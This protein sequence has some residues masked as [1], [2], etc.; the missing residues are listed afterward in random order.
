LGRFLARKKSW[1]KMKGRDSRKKEGN[2]GVRLASLLD[3]SYYL[4]RRAER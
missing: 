3:I 2:E 4:N 1:R